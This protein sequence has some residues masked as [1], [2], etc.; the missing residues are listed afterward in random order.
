MSRKFPANPPHPERT[1]WGCDRYCAADALICGN[2]SERTQHPCEM[3]GEDWLDW[4]T[5]ATRETQVV[6]KRR[7]IPIQRE[8]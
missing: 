3:F 5:S 6:D 4:D 2:G 7:V 8:P 1:C